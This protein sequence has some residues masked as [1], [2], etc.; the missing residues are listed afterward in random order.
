MKKAIEGGI[1]KVSV[2]IF[3]CSFLALS[4]VASGAEMNDADA[5]Q[6]AVSGQAM[7]KDL[8]FSQKNG[9]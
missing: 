1:M 2:L 7:E 6:S 3:S 4:G 5:V 8:L 9:K